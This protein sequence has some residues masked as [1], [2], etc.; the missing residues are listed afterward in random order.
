MI[1]WYLWVNAA[2]YGVFAVLCS[3]RVAATARSLG[4]TQLN[5]SGMS[6]YV[7]VYGGLQFGLAVFF[8]WAAYRP[9][10]QRVGLLLAVCLYMPIVVFRWL[11]VM[12]HWPVE[13]MTLAVGALEATLLA[14]ALGLWFKVR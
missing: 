10:L 5:A 14:V 3:L 12:R 7:T 6:E 4:Y 2:L 1:A 9:E 11:S 13:R 8:A